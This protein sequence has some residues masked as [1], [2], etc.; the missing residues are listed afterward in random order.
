VGTPILSAY[1]GIVTQSRDIFKNNGEYDSYGRLVVVRS[2]VKGQTIDVFY[3]HLHTREVK[4]TDSVQAG[5]LIGTLGYNGNV[6]P[7][8]PAGAHLHFEVRIGGQVVD[9]RPYLPSKG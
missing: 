3:A 7:A 6:I 1:S 9:P 5:E 2:V 8:G 4:E